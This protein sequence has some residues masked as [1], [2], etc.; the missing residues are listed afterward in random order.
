[1]RIRGAVGLTSTGKA[2]VTYEVEDAV[3]VEEYNETMNMLEKDALIRY[4]RLNSE[5][6]GKK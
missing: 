2:S 3:S 6:G 4:A 5:I 1:M